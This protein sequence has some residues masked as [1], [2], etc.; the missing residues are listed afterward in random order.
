[1]Y[2]WYQNKLPS[3]FQDMFIP[4]TDIHDYDTRQSSL[5]YCP[6]FKT[7][8][9]KSRCS[10][11]APYMWNL[12]IKADINPETSEAVFTKSVKQCIKVGIL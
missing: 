10:Y 5:L 2:R 11:R 6:K 12:I 3:M 8:L 9:G 7:E 4:I 1:M